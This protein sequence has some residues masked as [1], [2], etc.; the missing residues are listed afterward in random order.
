MDSMIASNQPA[1]D[2]TLPDLS[3]TP[4]TLSAYRGQMVV[5]NFWSA[6]CPWAVRADA[7]LR[8][9]VQSWDSQVVLL[10][11][12]ANANESVEQLAEAAIV[13]RVPVVLHD[14]DRTAADLF[15]A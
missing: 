1:P 11:I 12:A 9:L 4:H 8:P 13:R 3:G 2:F 6:E 15:G 7:A 10:A 5:L 14:T